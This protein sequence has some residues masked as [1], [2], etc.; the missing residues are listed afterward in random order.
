MS[1]MNERNEQK[2]SNEKKPTNILWVCFEIKLKEEISQEPLCERPVIL[3]FFA[4]ALLLVVLL[5]FTLGSPGL[6]TA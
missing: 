1:E 4:A 6:P 5:P 2:I 3:V